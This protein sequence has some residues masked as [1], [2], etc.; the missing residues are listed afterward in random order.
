[1]HVFEAIRTRR[2]IKKFDPNYVM[3]EE[4]IKQL[5]SL[6]LEAPTAFNIQHWRF[7]LVRNPEI[8]KQIR[9]AAWDQEQVTDASLLIL[10]CA[11]LS[12]WEDRP[13]RYWANATQEAR[14]F[15]LPAIHNYYY[16][17]QQV[18]RDEVMRSCGL[19]GQ[20]IMLAAKAM[21]L[22]SCPMDGFDYDAVGKIINLPEDHTISFMIVVGKKAQEPHAKPGQLPYQEVVKIDR[23]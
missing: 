8:R 3:S 16:G 4:E 18:I 6:A 9:A 15:I 20:T 5:L 19:A 2:A 22:D 1:M 10:L 13:E 21:G 12:A 23:F 11:K 14:D 17:K 7:L